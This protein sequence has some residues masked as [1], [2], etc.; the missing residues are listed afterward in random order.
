MNMRRPSLRLPLILA[1]LSV[2]SGCAEDTPETRAVSKVFLTTHPEFAIKR[3]RIV[4][5]QTPLRTAKIDFTSPSRME[6]MG[7]ANLVY[8]MQE[9]GSVILVKEAICTKSR[10]S[11]FCF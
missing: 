9:N 3:I 4:K 10:K 8:G 7:H 1:T 11:H 6:P 2:L 5:E